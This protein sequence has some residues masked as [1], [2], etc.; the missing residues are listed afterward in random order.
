MSNVKDALLVATGDD[1]DTLT[2]LLAAAD[3]FIAEH[4]GRAFGG[5]TFTEVHAG[6]TGLLFL[7]NYPVSAVAGVRVD[8][9]RQFGTDTILPAANYVLHADRGVIES[10]GGVF[11]RSRGRRGSAGAPGTVQVTY[12]TPTDAV[13]GAVKEALSQLVGHW[14]RLAKTSEDLGGVLL[15]ETSDG[16]ETKQYTWSLASG[17]KVP[18]GVLQILA[19][20]RVPAA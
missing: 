2:R 16:A 20:F 5:G 12:S 9:A 13:P 11:L 17:L 15:T 6:N 1:D 4:T 8:A 3:S 19:P 7:R 18:A 10:V 14:Y